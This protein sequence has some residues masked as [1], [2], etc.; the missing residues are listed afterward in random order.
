MIRDYAQELKQLGLD[1]LRAL[2]F[3]LAKTY[4]PL[5]P[6]IGCKGLLCFS[7]GPSCVGKG[8]RRMLSR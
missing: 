7:L 2:I 8:R 6:S 1:G 3:I 5:A 4:Q